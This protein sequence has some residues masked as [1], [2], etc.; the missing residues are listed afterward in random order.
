MVRRLTWIATAAGLVLALLRMERLLRSATQGPPWQLVLVAALLLGGV[1]TWVALSYRARLWGIVAA[2]AAGLILATIRIAAPDTAIFGLIPTPA[3]IGETVREIAFGF[4][5]IRFGTAPVVPVA[6]IILLLTWLFW[7]FGAVIVWS[8]TSGRPIIAVIPGII[9]YLQLATMDRL[10]PGR[11]W[12][13]AFVA[14]LLGSLVAVAHDERTEGTGRL[15]DRD[16]RYVPAVSASRPTLYIVG[17]VVVALLGTGL[18]SQQIPESGLLNWRS[19]TGFGNG[20]FG[21]VSYNL[22]VGVQQS[23]TSQSDTPAFTATV[24]GDIDPG[25]LYWKLIALESFDGTNWFPR[26]SLIRAPEPGAPWENPDQSFIGPTV[27]VL[28]D[29]TIASLRQ[30]YLPAAYTPVGLASQSEILTES[31]RIR[32]DG[33]IRFDALTF[34]GLNYQITSQVPEPNF[35]VLASADGALSPIFTEAQQNGV[36]TG[37]AAGVAERPVPEDIEDFLDLPSSIAEGAIGPFSRELTA[38]ADTD[39]E[40]ALFI[41]AFLRGDNFTYDATI[42][43]GHSAQNIED[44]LID[45]DSPNYHT[46]YCEQFATA[47]AVMARTLGMPSRVI[48]G[49]APGDVDANGTVTVRQSDAHSWVEIWF[50][51]QGWVKFDPTPRRQADNPGLVNSLGFDPR[52]YIPISEDN[53]EETERGANNAFNPPD[54]DQLLEELLGE[55]PTPDALD[56]SGLLGEE[57]DGFSLP[58]AIGAA[59]AAALAVIPGFKWW[60]RRRRLERLKTGDITGAWNEIIDQLTDLGA[61]VPPSSTPLEVAKATHDSMEPLALT[62]TRVVY[63]PGDP[64]S[65]ARVS[66][67]ETSYRKT[68]QNLRDRHSRLRR[69]LRWFN[70]AS[71]RRRRTDDRT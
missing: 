51:E 7:V 56:G 25:D 42:D 59:L 71:L 67:V 1:I 44:W 30:N 64:L 62:Y 52:N 53:P 34:E 9:L 45:P 68:E 66:W 65:E 31:F 11:M 20:I 55:A 21:G 61:G 41:E 2:N 16:N 4:E 70:P 46:G 14:V 49:F 8:I 57:S 5:L 6:G 19:R 43:P 13:W 40:R 18:F 35:D 27:T 28:Q 26:R 10:P 32:E 54:R 36:F 69:V 33:A 12:T 23:L 50:P 22:F 15:R 38:S 24:E 60:R 63:G 29:I 17:V 58:L 37:Q 39:F 47:M 3:T 48:L